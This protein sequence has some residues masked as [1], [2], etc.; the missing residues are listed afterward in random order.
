MSTVMNGKDLPF[1]TAFLS[2][3]VTVQLQGKAYSKT[4]VLEIDMS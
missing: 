4:P 1:K 2:D 3:K